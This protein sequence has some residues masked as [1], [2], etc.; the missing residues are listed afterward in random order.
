MR[1]TIIGV[2]FDKNS[3]RVK[4]RKPFRM[5]LFAESLIYGYLILTSHLFKRCS[6]WKKGQTCR[7]KSSNGKLL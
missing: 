2:F 3:E 7:C 4:N 1:P 6:V 5:F